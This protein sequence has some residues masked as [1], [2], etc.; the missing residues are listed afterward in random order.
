[1]LD[2]SKIFVQHGL[3]YHPITLSVINAK[4][5]V[6]GRITRVS[7]WTLLLTSA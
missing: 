4:E 6:T 3:Q 7:H 1:M 5:A 2:N